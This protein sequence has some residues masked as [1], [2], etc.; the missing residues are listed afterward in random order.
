MTSD[1]RTA[2]AGPGHLPHLPQHLH[3]AHSSQV[4]SYYIYDLRNI[5]KNDNILIYYSGHRYKDYAAET[6]YWQPINAKKNKPS[7][8]ISEDEL[9]SQLRAIKAKHILVVADSCFSGSILRGVEVLDAQD[10]K[11]KTLLLAFLTT[12]F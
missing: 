12:I 8:W 7:S 6:A 4:R 5:D 10:I 11:K 3:P 1:H 2:G 9:K